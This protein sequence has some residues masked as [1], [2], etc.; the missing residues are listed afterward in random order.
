MKDIEEILSIKNQLQADKAP[1]E[2][3]W[4]EISQYILPNKADFT[5]VYGLGQNRRNHIYESVGEHSNDLFASSVMGIVANPAARW[6]TYATVDED[7]NSNEEVQDWLD[8]AGKI[9]LN[10]INQAQAKF[11]GNLKS[12]LLDIGAFGTTSMLVMPGR[13]SLFN[14]RSYSPKKILIA[15]NSEGTVD[16]VM[17][18]EKY[19][20]RQLLQLMKNSDWDLHKN[21]QDMHERLEEKIDVIHFFYSNND[22]DPEKL[23]TNDNMKFRSCYIDVKNKK[24]M[25]EQGFMELPVPSARWDRVNDEVWGRGQ[26]AVAINEL[27]MLNLANR[28]QIIAAEKQLNPPLQVPSDGSFGRIDLSA[29]AI[30]KVMPGQ[31]IKP[32]LTNGNIVF[33]M[34]WMENR[35]DIIRR[36]FYVD[37]LQLVG[38]PQMTATEVLQR[39]DEKARIIA[40]SIGM[41]NAE[42][43][44]PLVERC[45]GI[46]LRAKRLPPPPE[47]LRG[48]EIKVVYVSPITRA[49]R[50]AEA[51]AILAYMQNLPLFAQADPSVIDRINIEMGAQ[52]LATITGLPPSIIRQDDEV[53]TIRNAKAQ[54]QQDAM[55]AAQLQQGSEIAKNAAQA[56]LI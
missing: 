56:G 50:G 24:K 27:K 7:I 29:G 1:F 17:L 52:E 49:Q 15:E 47:M 9:V 36:A 23:E 51:Q 12:S 22:Y 46:A 39:M 19:T 2:N 48:Q 31:E 26:G 28:S 18:C 6:F 44:G 33:D 40:P 20:V 43:I 14:F 32:I 54:A 3:L 5:R 41:V 21:V 11:Y 55:M 10:G 25:K 37:Q 16:Q 53:E 45:L 42:L 30:N 38:G 8:T 4:Q 34:Q 13:E 35:R